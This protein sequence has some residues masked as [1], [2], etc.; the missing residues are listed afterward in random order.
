MKRGAQGVLKNHQKLLGECHRIGWKW[1]QVWRSTKKIFKNEMLNMTFC[2]PFSGLTMVNIQ[3]WC[4]DVYLDIWMEKKT[5]GKPWCR[6]TLKG[7]IISEMVCNIIHIY[8]YRIA[9]CF[10]DL[11]ICV[12]VCEKCCKYVPIMVCIY[13]QFTNLEWGPK[14]DSCCC[15]PSF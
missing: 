2:P 8:I 5:M 12:C 3:R 7:L 14:W 10:I 1:T 4:L 15:Q 13:I 6:I 9:S 11:Y